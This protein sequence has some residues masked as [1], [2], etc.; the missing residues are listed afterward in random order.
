MTQVSPLYVGPRG[1]GWALAVLV[2]GGEDPPEEMWVPGRGLGMAGDS[3][4]RM[5]GA[6]ACVQTHLG[7]SRRQ[8]A[9][10]LHL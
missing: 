3:R 1:G 6:W 4:R 5:Q 8:R 7:S 2:G 10:F 9:E